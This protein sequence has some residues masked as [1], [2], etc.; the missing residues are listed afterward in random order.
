MN[1]ETLLQI[2]NQGENASVEFKNTSVRAES[3]AREFVAFANSQGGVVLIGIE[4]SGEISG[5]SGEKNFEEWC[6][7][8]ARNN[9]HP[10][11]DIHFSTLELEGKAIGIVRVPKGKDKPYQTSDSRF[12]IR[13]GSTNRAA[14]INEL[15]RLFQQSGVFHFDVTPVEN[16]S[17][18]NLNLQK[19][20]SYFTNYKLDFEAL[21]EEEKTTLLHNAD[22]L[23]PNH[24]LTVGGL[25]IF[26]INPQRYLPMA[27]ISFAKIKGETLSADLIDKQSIEGTLDY[28]VDITT[29]IIKNH[30]SDP[31][32]II[33]NKRESLTRQYPDKVF[34]ELIV[35]ACCHR[36]Y[37]IHGSKTRVFMFD[38]R[39][40]VI[41]PGRLPNTVTVEKLKAGVSYA[42]NPIIVKFMENMGYVDKLGRGLP[43]V[44]REAL[45]RNKEVCFEE[46]GEEFKV[47]LF[48]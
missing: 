18:K 11:L 9:V 48:L 44:Y 6:S 3:L 33:G 43:M 16:T 40:E 30:I 8:V 29:S 10:P 21:S 17:L 47:T 39:L 38:N 1:R 13:V 45:E 2:I 28:Q 24:Q 19:V 26:G 14:S 42:V 4:D 7:N 32:T 35:N 22:I 41:S 27:S 25:L 46:I 31:S 20:A 15:M 5:M 36:N 23:T 37:S 34:R 12:F